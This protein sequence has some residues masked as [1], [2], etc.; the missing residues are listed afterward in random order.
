MKQYE[1]PL[2]KHIDTDE[3]SQLLV[4][5]IITSAMEDISKVLAANGLSRYA[6]GK[7]LDKMVKVLETKPAA[8]QLELELKQI[9]TD[10]INKHNEMRDARYEKLAEPFLE[11]FPPLSKAEGVAT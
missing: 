4:L 9:V 3:T 6:S 8:A 11:L 5:M 10:I 2:E 7:L 1:L